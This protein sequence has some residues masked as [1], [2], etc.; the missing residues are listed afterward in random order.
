MTAAGGLLLAGGGHSHALVLKR[1][2]MRP[3]R[4]P[5]HSITLVN[6]SSTALYSG[7]VPGLIAGLYQ[8][9]EL[10]IDL[11]QLCDR[12]GVAFVEAEITGL[13]PQD[14]CLRLRDRPALHFDWL[15]LDVGSVSRP[16][17]AGIPIKPLEA[18]LAF[19][20]SEDPSDPEA[21]AG[22]RSGSCRPGSG[23]GAATPLAAAGAATATAQRT[24]G[25]RHPRGAATG[26]DRID[27]GQHATQRTQPALHRKPGACLAGD[28]RSTA[29]SRWPNPHRSLPEG[30]RPSIPVRQRRLCR[31]QRITP[32][33]IWGV[34]SARRTPLGHQS[35]SGLPGPT[36]APLAP[37]TP[38]TATDRQP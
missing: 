12:A 26:S 7:M 31:D 9:D 19:L 36:P 35:G 8:R 25:S 3:A 2:A 11:R 21:P 20:E 23:P 6:R 22:D 28:E 33:G 29:G 24:A 17:A 4:R 27:R 18:S 10:A 32:A 37:T 15:S 16:S 30:G 1:W 5:Q 38:S 13:N 14:K 34:G